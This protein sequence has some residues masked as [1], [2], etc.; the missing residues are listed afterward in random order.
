MP[1]IRINADGAKPVLH[2]GGYD[3]TA[4][5]DLIDEGSGPVIVMTHGCKYL[6]GH[7]A[8]CPHGKILALHPRDLPLAHTGWPRQL[9]FGT[10]HAG[11]GLGVAF[12]WAARGSLHRAQQRAGEAGRALAVILREIHRRMPGRPVH[13]VAHSMGLELAMEA[14]HRV[15][16]GAVDR[17]IG[18][19]GACYHARVA[20]ALQTPA[21]RAAEFINV[22]SRE[23]DAF[24]WLFEWLIAP[25]RAGDRAI[26]HGIEMPNAVTLQMDCP[27]T[28]DHLDRI[29]APIAGPQRRICHWSS[30]TRPGILRFYNDLLRRPE[31]FALAAL[32]RGLPRPAPR[33]SR[34]IAAP[35][36]SLPLP[37]V[38]KAS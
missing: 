33:W 37:F 18:L 29:G 9:G 13:V 15:P 25:P 14:L 22:T 3:I 35:R 8:H 1:M 2:R 6:P 5:L 21:G 34:L 28:L 16:A 32:R 31:Q 24:D 26:G 7:P 23:N 19:S 4:A 17:I 10:G 20:A 36:V 11:E 38:Q 12:G 27:A 30:Y